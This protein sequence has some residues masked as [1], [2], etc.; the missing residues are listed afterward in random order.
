[1]SKYQSFIFKDY[2]FNKETKTLNLS[3]SLDEAVDF[4]ET[5][6]LNC[7]FSDYDDQELDLAIQCLFFMAG[8]SY[9]KTYIPATIKVLKGNLDQFGADFFS[10]T[11][12]KGLGEFWYVNDLDPKTEVLFPV[13]AETT[14]LN[15]QTERSG[16]LIGL[17]GG[18]DSLVVVEALR[19]T[20]LEITT[21]SLNHRSQFEPLVNR[22][23]LDHIYVERVINPKLLE[24]NEGDALNGHVPISGILAAVGLVVAVLSGKRDIV[25]G[26]EQ[27]ANEPTLNY[28][29]VDI[30]HQYS[31]SQEFEVDFQGYIRHMVGDSIRYYSFLR[32]LSELRIAEIFSKIGLSKYIDVFSSCN[33]AYT[34]HSDKM[35]WCGECP[36]CAFIFLVLTPFVGRQQLEEIWGG[37]NLLLDDNLVPTY[38]NLLGISGNKPLD[39]VGEI[40][41]SRTAMRLA[42]DIYPE[43]KQRYSFEL[44]DDYDYKT[45]SSDEMPEDIK[46]VF[47]RF[48]SSF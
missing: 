11:Y 21:W 48:I 31:K 7:E 6:R 20:D 36:K 34:L 26:N 22:I 9:F 47:V 41:E 27:T 25:V 29:G 13:N 44:P 32:P 19:Q 8:V 14:P 4:T 40:R 15:D 30:N 37:K 1:M 43:L 10:K 24:L 17:G 33:R 3:Y 42:Q 16:L 35:F 18:K 39:C 12:E 45:T 38:E 28:R 23:G 46:Q 2:E 5:Y